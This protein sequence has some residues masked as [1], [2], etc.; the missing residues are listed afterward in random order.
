MQRRSDKSKKRTSK[1]PNKPRYKTSS[2]SKTLPQNLH[3]ANNPLNLD[4]KTFPVFPKK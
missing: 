2:K 1:A 4:I 3:K